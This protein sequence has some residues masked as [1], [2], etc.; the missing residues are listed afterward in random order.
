MFLRGATATALMLGVLVLASGQGSA[1]PATPPS[2]TGE[3]TISGRAE[4]GARLTASTGTWSG[5]TPIIWGD[6]V[7]VTSPSKSEG[8]E[9][10][11]RG[12]GTGEKGKGPG[13][14]RKF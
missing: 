5:S 1:A 9:A 11:N 4:Q 10:G 6:D 3:P 13:R 2:N 12:Q 8:Q 7:F 14:S